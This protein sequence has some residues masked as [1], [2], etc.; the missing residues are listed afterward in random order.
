VNVLAFLRHLD[1]LVLALA[2][3]LFLIAGLPLLGWAVVAVFWVVQ[4]WIVATVKQRALATG[5][6]SAVMRAV[7]LS[8]MVRLVLVTAAVV[9]AG[10]ADRDAGVPAALLTAALFSIA[11][12]TQIATAP[13][14]G[15]S[16]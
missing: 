5:D 13:P 12:G 1:L 11:L 16:R 8:M 9:V 2:L 10:V 14:A 6:R 3:P 7:A 15:A 4:R